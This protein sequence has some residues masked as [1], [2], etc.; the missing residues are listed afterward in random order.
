MT[1]SFTRRTA[2]LAVAGCALAGRAG[3]QAGWPS[4]PIR[5][6]VPFA[7]GASVD[8]IARIIA[9]KLS[10]RFGA[11]VVVENRAGAGGMTGTAFVA[12]QPADGHVLLFTANPFVIA[13]LLVPAGQRPPY[14]PSKDLQPV[15]QVAA[16][17]LV[18]T[19]ANDLGVATLPE[20][21]AAAR[22]NPQRISYGSAGIGTINHLSVEMLA[23]MAGIQ[24]L[25]VPFTGL[26]PAMAAFVGGHVKMMVGSFPSVLPLVRE[27]RVRALAVTSTRRS[28][29]M[30]ELPTVAEAGVAG[31]EIEAWWGMFGPA[32]L[33]ASVTERLNGEINLLLATL[34]VLE[35]LARD[36]AVPTPG[37]AQDFERLLQSE[38]PRT[39]RLI[40]DANIAG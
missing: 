40:G 21:I 17:P 30:P 6:V 35:L 1:S 15:A 27:G 4:R 2:L 14:D 33:P 38:I 20:L 37:S 18:V 31:Y 9:P 8:A 34:E 13:P 36:G 10:A 24:L 19:V 28:P 29:L 11:A 5:I 3:A 22:A 26:G 23:G 12:G 25:H 39:R 7:P 16:A 32:G